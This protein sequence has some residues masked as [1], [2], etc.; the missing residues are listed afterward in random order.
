MN[1]LCYVK[2]I[3]MM[4]VLLKSRDEVFRMILKERLY[5]VVVE[6]DRV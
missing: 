4:Y 6:F 2:I 1:Y 3:G 5:V